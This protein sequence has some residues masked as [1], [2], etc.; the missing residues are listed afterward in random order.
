MCTR[1][2]CS[3]MLECS[4][5]V[6]KHLFSYIPKV[7]RNDPVCPSV[8]Q[9]VCQ[10]VCLTCTTTPDLIYKTNNPG[11]NFSETKLVGVKF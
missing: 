1:H 5:E 9:S 4:Q 11:A 6:W 3:L 10:F 8:C 7:Y 2:S